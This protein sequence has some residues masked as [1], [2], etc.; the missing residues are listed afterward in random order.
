M[1]LQLSVN[2]L[3]SVLV[4]SQIVLMTLVAGGLFL[5]YCTLSSD[6]FDLLHNLWTY[7]SKIY[8]TGAN[9]IFAPVE[10]AQYFQEHQFAQTLVFR[11]LNLVFSD[12]LSIRIMVLLFLLITGLSLY[13]IGRHKF[14]WSRQ[15]AVIFSLCVVAN[16]FF[17]YHLQ[18]VQLLFIAL[19]ILFILVVYQS[20]FQLVK[21]LLS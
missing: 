20:H 14:Y 4:R 1:K 12:F 19:P 6:A 2:F 5:G 8:A 17:V 11:L 18:H 7:K 9:N 10:G 13:T 21:R 16:P 15:T 3:E